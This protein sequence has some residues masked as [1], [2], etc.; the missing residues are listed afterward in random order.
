MKDSTVRTAG[1]LRAQKPEVLEQIRH[2]MR[3]ESK[4]YQKGDAIELPMPAI[5]SSGMKP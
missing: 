3:D 5:L 1:L 4:Q 2:A